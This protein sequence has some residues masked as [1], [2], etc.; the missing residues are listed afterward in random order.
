MAEA[1]SSR[2]LV[3]TAPLLI[4]ASIP[5]RKI[6]I[7][8]DIYGMV[9]TMA[10]ALLQASNDEVALASMQGQVHSLMNNSPADAGE[11]LRNHLLVDTAFK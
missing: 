3:A 1:S 9:P 5:L 6:D 11:V 8:S 4:G 7:L 2:G 10:I